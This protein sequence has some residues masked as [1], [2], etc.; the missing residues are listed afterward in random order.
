M[1]T[2]DN[3]Q[4]DSVISIKEFFRTHP[5][6]LGSLLY[7]QLSAVGMIYDWTLY[8]EFQINILDFAE[9]NDFLLAAFKEPFVLIQGI[10]IVVVFVAYI[11]FIRYLLR[12][13]SFP[14]SV[15][16]LMVSVFTILLILYTFLP[17][18]HRAR[19]NAETVRNATSSFVRVYLKEKETKTTAKQ[20]HKP[21][22]MIGTMGKFVFLYDSEDNRAIAIP[23]A[24]IINIEF[25]LARK[26]ANTGSKNPLWLKFSRY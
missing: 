17:A 8:H 4:S 23:I 11:W 26:N 10:G 15:N 14:P 18:R 16:M 20:Y 12:R 1:N 2:L 25:G 19:E 3:G 6:I 7:I 24:N 21:L 13:R 22:S 9:A 5:G